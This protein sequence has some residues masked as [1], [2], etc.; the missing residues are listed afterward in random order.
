MH[1]EESTYEIYLRG[2]LGEVWKVRF[3]DMDMKLDFD[4]H[5]DPLTILTG[6]ISDQAALHGMLATF[7]DAGIPIISVNRTDLK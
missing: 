7:R 1:S 6:Q 2:H 3:E 4:L 5:G